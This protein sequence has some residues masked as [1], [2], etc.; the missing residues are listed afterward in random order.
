MSATLSATRVNVLYRLTGSGAP[1]S[2]VPAMKLDRIILDKAMELGALVGL[3]LVWTESQV[4]LTA[5]SLADYS[6]GAATTQFHQIVAARINATGQTMEKVTFDEINR[7]REG[8][9]VASGTG[10]PF[11]F[12]LWEDATQIVRMRIDSVPTLARTIDFMR[13]ALPSRTV[14]DSTTLP[15][16]DLMLVALEEASAAKAA[17]GLD[18]ETAARLKLG[19]GVIGEW[20]SDSARIVALEAG[21]LNA[22]RRRP[23]GVGAIVGR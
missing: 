7:L 17:A 8:M 10:D 6:L 21:R 16:S 14:A 3:G 19:A 12:A 4:T 9:T 5:N 13:S 22:L 20:K 11:R 1:S 15:F 2:D 23:Y 18:D